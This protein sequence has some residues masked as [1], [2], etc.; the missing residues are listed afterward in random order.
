MTI[1]IIFIFSKFVEVHILINNA[2]Q[3]IT[4]PP[5]YYTSLQR[6]ESAPIS[7]AAKKLCVY[8]A[9]NPPP[10][11]LL[12]SSLP[13]HFDTT[14]TL[15]NLLLLKAFCLPLQI[16]LYL[17]CYQES[18]VRKFYEFRTMCVSKIC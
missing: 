6:F 11:F 17:F 18:S 8:P 2:T 5:E 16:S 7:V 1:L 13:Y 12:I 14:P 10:P 9:G 3:T 4:R 15:L